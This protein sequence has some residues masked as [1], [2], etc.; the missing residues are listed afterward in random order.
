MPS[1]IIALALLA[2]L[3]LGALSNSLFSSTKQE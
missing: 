3:I 1:L 2:S